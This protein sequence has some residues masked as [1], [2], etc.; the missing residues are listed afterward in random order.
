M[1]WRVANRPKTSTRA[2]WHVA[3]ARLRGTA[4]GK[5]GTRFASSLGA[6]PRRVRPAQA[7]PGPRQTALDRTHRPPELPGRLFVARALEVAE[8]DGCL[9]PSRKLAKL[10]EHD[11]LK[12]SQVDGASSLLA[13]V[14]SI[15][16]RPDRSRA[17][18]RREFILA[19]AATR[20]ATPYSQRPTEPS[21][22]IEPA[23]RT[24][25][26]NVAWNASSASCESASMRRQT[27]STIG[28]CRSTSI[29]NASSAPAS[30]WATNRSRS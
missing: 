18:R 13:T 24:N 6:R 30:R 8:N 20:V 21:T 22:R 17:R 9:I 5:S 27:P 19:R 11:R 15:R 25:T 12:V 26:R 23:C 4:A 29:A 14:A 3:S 10:V 7:G 16:S 2:A 28:P 1:I